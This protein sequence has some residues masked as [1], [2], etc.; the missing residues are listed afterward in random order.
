[1]AHRAQPVE[2]WTSV[3][4]RLGRQAHGWGAR[5]LGKVL[6]PQEGLGSP[7]PSQRGRWGWWA[8]FS[9][10]WKVNWIGRRK[11]LSSGLGLASQARSWWPQCSTPAALAEG[12]LEGT[13][14]GEGGR[15]RGRG[16]ESGGKLPPS[17]LLLSPLLIV[18]AVNHTLVGLHRERVSRT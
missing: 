4:Q 17:R 1:M 18:Q 3:N 5:A 11:L 16:E 2:F 10:S 6:N 12:T 9:E 15:G 14:R 13:R 7:G 8:P